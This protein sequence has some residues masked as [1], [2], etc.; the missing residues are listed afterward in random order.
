MQNNISEF[1]LELGSKIKGDLRTDEMSRLLYST[2]ASIYQV[3]PYGVF[4]PRSY[5]EI[6]VAVRLASLYK[7]PLLPRGAGSSLA[8]QAVNEAL[9]IDTSR[10]LDAILDVNVEE[11]WVRAQAGVTLVRLN[12]YLKQFGVKYGPDPASGNRAVLGGIVG[13]NSSGSHSILYGMSADHVLATQII[14]ADGSMV[15]F[16]P[17]SDLAIENYRLERSLEGRI[18]TQISGLVQNSRNLEIIRAGTPRH[19]RRCGGYNL[20]RMTNGNGI[21]FRWPYDQRFNLSKLICGAEGTLGVMTEVTLNLVD[22]PKASGVAVVHFASLRAALEAVPTILE[23]NPSAIELIDRYG[24]YLA[25]SVP[26][27]AAR[28]KKF[29]QGNPDCILITEFYGESQKEIE[30]SLA[31][32]QA[33][34]QLRGVQTLAITN[35]L[36][37]EAIQS[38]WKVREGSLGILMS[39]RGDVKPLPIVDDA[40]VQPAHLADYI[41]QLETF[42]KQ[43]LDHDVAYFA[44]ASAGCLHVHS[45]LNAKLA[46]DIAKMP[47]IMQFTAELLSEYGGVLSSE[48]GDGRLRSW[49]NRHFY[50]DDLYGLFNQVKSTFDP[51]NIFN[52]G[53]IVDGQEMTENLRY[54]ANYH[55]LPVH[56]FLDFGQAPN[57][58]GVNLSSQQPGVVELGFSDAVEMCSGAGACRQLTGSMCPSFM[59]TREEKNSTRGRANALRAALSGRLAQSEFTGQNVFEIMDLCV[60]CKACKSE[61]P[62]SVDMAKI[63]AEFLFQYYQK[64]FMSLRSHFFANFGALSQLASG[65]MAPVSN[66]I[67]QNKLVR[68]FIN[69]LFA[70]APERRLPSFSKETFYRWYISQGSKNQ[71]STIPGMQLIL[72]ADITRNF[73]DPDTARAAYKVLTALGFNVIVP[74]VHDFGRPAFSKGDLRLARKKALIALEVLG[75]YAHKGIQIVGLEP[76]DISMFMDDFTALLPDDDRVEVVA[77][78]ALS[79]EEFLWRQMLAGKLDGFFKPQSGQILLHGHC[80]QKALI[81]IHKSKELLTYLGYQVQE[82]GSACCGMAGSFGYEAEHYDISL[83]MGELTL[84]PVIRAQKPDALIVAAGASCQEQIEQGTQRKAVHPA[85]VFLRALV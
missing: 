51:D 1:I 11:K 37:S 33:H 59:A 41:S 73:N 17:K 79:F 81:G 31:N 16:G 54:G 20:D 32:L 62:S 48:H 27:Y 4:I 7:V 18:Y 70:I 39:M 49:L 2:D 85:V 68:G 65:S 83:Q 40:A 6:Q 35:L 84:F 80:H 30:A 19:W 12:A 53:D 63:K 76:S 50:G 15:E 23:L 60:S 78:Q 66:W 14:L 67:V 43:E 13:N 8:G 3:M 82:A 57:I 61:C 25:Q 44:H 52:P 69:R 75:P 45:L 47:K 29:V 21:S 77:A 34:L 42:C 64:H 5:E 28:M 22:L 56:S 58:S 71:K 55:N 38:V 46:S 72:L 9:V 74:P 10:Y 24:L 26:E 36:E